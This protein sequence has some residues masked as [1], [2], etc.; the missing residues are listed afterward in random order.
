M[1]GRTPK[2]I[3]ANPGDHA[4][5]FINKLWI[6]PSGQKL[7]QFKLLDWQETIV[8]D[9]FGTIN[10]ET[11]RRQF[12]DAIIAMAKKNGKSGLVAAIL[13]YALFIGFPAGSELYSIAASKE[14]AAI[15]YKEAVNII[16]HTSDLAS[17]CH[18]SDQYKRIS[19]RKGKT[20]GSVYEALS[21]EKDTVHGKKPSLLLIDEAALV[22]ADLWLALE[23]SMSTQQEPLTI[24]ISHATSLNREHIYQQKL[25]TARKVR[26]GSLNIP[27]LYVALWELPIDKE[28][29]DE[30]LWQ[31]ANP[32]LGTLKSLDSMRRTFQQALRSP[33]F[34]TRFR[35]WD[36]NQFT[37]SDDT[38]LFQ[39]DWDACQSPETRDALLERFKGRPAFISAD[40]SSTE[41]LTALCLLFP[42]QGTET[43]PTAFFQFFHPKDGHEQRSEKDGVNYAVWSEQGHIVLTPG[44]TVDYEA[45]RRQVNEWRELFR[46]IQFG[47]DKRFAADLVKRLSEQDGVDC[48]DI[49]QGFVHLTSP[50]KA[51]ETNV[52]NHTLQ[53]DGNPIAAWN[54]GNCSVERGHADEIFPSKKRSNGRIDGVAA[55]VMAQYCNERNPNVGGTNY[56]D[57]PNASIY[58]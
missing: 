7:Q 43:G 46:I 26:D 9:L 31:L 19:V 3:H 15:L 17:R 47:Y 10:T 51:V 8:R 13:V 35:Q 20:K 4:V 27:T 1:A 45:V 23:Q 25:V 37:E 53:H 22:E 14:Q 44:K 34:S 30:S 29:R 5:A 56:F 36:L 2:K 24:A 50:S 55:L 57:D 12:T 49:G 18:Y 11:G 32:S 40:L 54:V 52:L 41:D 48:V 58:L 39:A 16:E 6:Q 28:W 33:S 42:P 38:W 21:S